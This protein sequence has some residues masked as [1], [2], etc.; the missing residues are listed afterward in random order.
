VVA[1]AD[2]SQ[3][4]TDRSKKGRRSSS[5]LD[6][7]LVITREVGSINKRRKERDENAKLG[8]LW[9]S[10]STW[11]YRKSRTGETEFALG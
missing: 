9:A 3:V 11:E 5:L 8:V 2:T 4:Y 1:H 10:R 6:R 7:T